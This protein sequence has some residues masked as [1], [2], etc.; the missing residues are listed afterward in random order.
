M[1]KTLCVMGLALAL[2]LIAE[3]R[4]AADCGFKICFGVSCSKWN[5]CGDCGY[6]SFPAVDPA[7]FGLGGYGYPG[8]PMPYP[9][10]APPAPAQ[11]PARPAQYVPQWGNFSGYQPVGY[12]FPMYYQGPSYW[13]GY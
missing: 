4:A 12:H 9:Y 10:A 8:Y 13:Y 2:T 3:R 11:A 7:L 1:K 6:P 5:G